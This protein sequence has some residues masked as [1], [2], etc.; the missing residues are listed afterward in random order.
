MHVRS[1]IQQQCISDDHSPLRLDSL[2]DSS[3]DDSDCLPVN[4]P[5]PVTALSA[6]SVR[7]LEES[8]ACEIHC[9]THVQRVQYRVYTYWTRCAPSE[10]R[11]VAHEWSRNHL[12]QCHHIRVSHEGS[13]IIRCTHC[14]TAQRIEPFTKYKAEWSKETLPRGKG[15]KN[16]EKKGGSN[17]KMGRPTQKEPTLENAQRSLKRL[18]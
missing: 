14:N 9:E 12:R 11:P 17:A 4:T 3:D 10:K 15:L 16:L 18:N 8:T 7:I 13:A 2:L 5:T 6:S 1:T